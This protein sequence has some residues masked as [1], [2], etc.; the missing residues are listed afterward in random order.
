M[1][2]PW[3]ERPTHLR[4]LEQHGAALGAFGAA[5]KTDFGFGWLTTEGRI[6]PDHDLELWINC[7]MTHCFSLLTLEGFPQFAHLADHGVKVLSTYF[8]DSEHGGYFSKIGH[9]GEPTDDSKHAYAHSFVVLAASSAVA[10]GRDG[11]QE[12]LDDALEVLESRFFEATHRLHSDVY[13]RAWTTCEEYRGINANMHSVE[14]LLSASAV[15]DRADLLN[16]AVGILDRAINE[17][18][19]GN[20]WALPEHY[21]PTWEVL[22]E[23]NR[24]EPA[25]PFRPYGATIGHWFEWARLSLHAKAGL[26]ARGDAAPEWMLEG[27]LALLTKGA[28]TFGSDG[29]PGFAYTLDWDGNPVVAERMHW[30][31]NEAIGAAAVAYAVT[32]DAT[33]AESYEQWWEYAAA[34]F[35]DPE[36]QSWAHE[37]SATNGES[38]TV[39]AGK[40]DIYHAYQC[41]LLPRIPVWPPFAAA[42]ARGEVR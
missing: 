10:A 4:W 29:A 13:D 5:S 27:A 37:L 12:L 33:W 2:K 23:Y 25:H 19:R 41:T 24:D 11:A 40:P 8:R 21:S 32:G 15:M 18:S 14:A 9:D 35:I 30:V 42:L 7:R 3:L 36:D 20:N 28:D 22:A 34:H 16:R 1:K 38:A 26:E 31:I 39:W 17:F 6:D